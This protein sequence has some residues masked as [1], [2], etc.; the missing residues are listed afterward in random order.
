MLYRYETHCHCSQ[1]SQCGCNTSQELVQ[2][3]YNAGYAGLILTDHFI[4]GNTSVNRRLPWDERMRAYFD[5]YLDAKAAAE[6]MDFDVIFGLEHAYGDGKEVLCYGIDLAFL[7][8]NPDIEGM[9]LDVFAQRVHA[10]G[11]IIIQAHP[12]RDR[13]YINMAVQ[14]QLDIVD[15]V[16]VY[17]A[18]NLPEENTRA[19]QAARER[20][21]I[22]TSG[23]D[24][25]RADNPILDAA[26]VA[27]P[28]RVRS[29]EELVAALKRRD[30]HL[31]VEGKLVSDITKDF[32]P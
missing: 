9:S 23:G 32:L 3:Y 8:A 4:Y 24:N 22:L 10:Y 13:S 18:G 1:A 16:E 2:A 26:G 19:L 5:A 31:I 17:N 25:H 6:A 7:L 11:G 12:Y 30:H 21:F 14:P 28:Y 20:D 29:G 15:G 27:F